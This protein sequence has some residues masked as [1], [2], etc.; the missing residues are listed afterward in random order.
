MR[1]RKGSKVEVLSKEEVPSGAWRCTEILWGNGHSYDVKYDWS[2]GSTGSPLTGRVSRKHIRPCPPSVGDS[3]DWLPGDLAEVLDNISWK[4]VQLEGYERELR[5]QKSFLRVR[6][7][8]QHDRWVIV[9]NVYFF[10]I[11]YSKVV[12]FL[13]SERPSFQEKV[14]AV[15]FPQNLLGEKHMHVSFTNRS[16]FSEMELAAEIHRL[17]LHAYRCTME[18]LYASG[19]LRREHEELMTNLTF[20]LVNRSTY[21]CYDFTFYL[22]PRRRSR[23]NLY[24]LEVFHLMDT[25]P[26]NMIGNLLYL[27]CKLIFSC[28]NTMY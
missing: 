15:A 2:P 21:P 17:E 27:Q 18:V 4:I 11:W 24:H 20:N 6:Q 12:P 23:V 22:F 7:S 8:W 26:V 5:V 9:G 28:G 3:V 10:Q 1:F 13:V 19:P 25:I 14:V 16:R